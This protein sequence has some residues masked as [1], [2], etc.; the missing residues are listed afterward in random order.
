MN[1]HGGG[2]A[3]CCSSNLELWNYFIQQCDKRKICCSNVLGFRN[4][5]AAGL[6]QVGWGK[7]GLKHLEMQSVLQRKH[8]ALTL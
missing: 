4:T 6:T 2:G 7:S 3:A 8:N 5:S 1:F